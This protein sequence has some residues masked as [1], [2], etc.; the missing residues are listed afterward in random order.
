MHI[1]TLVVVASLLA[2]R[3]LKIRN[4]SPAVERPFRVALRN[5]LIAWVGTFVLI[6]AGVALLYVVANV[7]G[8][9]PQVHEW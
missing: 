3:W 7:F 4:E 2:W 9:L 6:I 8:P 1:A 5:E